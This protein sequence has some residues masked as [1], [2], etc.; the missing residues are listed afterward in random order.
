MTFVSTLLFCFSSL[1]QFQKERN[2]DQQF[3][4]V[5]ETLFYNLIA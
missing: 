4:N 2:D 1:F 3:L 5:I